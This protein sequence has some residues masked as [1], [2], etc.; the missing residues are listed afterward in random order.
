MTWGKKY[1]IHEQMGDLVKTGLI[2]PPVKTESS[3]EQR[4]H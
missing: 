2:S 3:L 1:E 4:I